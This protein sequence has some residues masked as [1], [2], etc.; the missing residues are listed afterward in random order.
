MADFDLGQ[1]PEIVI[2]ACENVL[3]ELDFKS[4]RG[5]HSKL[6]SGPETE[7]L[8][9]VFGRIARWLA[10]TGNAAVKVNAK[11][12]HLIDLLPHLLDDV[13]VAEIMTAKKVTSEKARQVNSGAKNRISEFALMWRSGFEHGVAALG[14]A[15]GGAPNFQVTFFVRNAN[16]Q[17]TFWFNVVEILN[18]QSA[19][20]I[21]TTARDRSVSLSRVIREMTE[22]PDYGKLMGI[23][24]AA[25][26][27]KKKAAIAALKGVAYMVMAVILCGAVYKALPEDTQEAIKKAAK[28]VWEK[29]SG[30]ISLPAGSTITVSGER[31]HVGQPPA[32]RIIPD[33]I[34]SG[35]TENTPKTHLPPL[36]IYAS[37]TLVPISLSDS[38]PGLEVSA[39][40]EPGH[41]SIS[42]YPSP[43]F[44][45]GSVKPVAFFFGDNT[46]AMG[47]VGSDS[48]V[49]STE[50]IFS[51]LGKPTLVTVVIY[52]IRGSDRV[53][54]EVIDRQVTIMP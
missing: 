47:S 48:W 42:A 27:R 2:S 12:R 35:V 53:P 17:A 44:R 49:A 38:G 43:R 26:K 28:K 54:L 19:R 15:E 52:E 40:F 9:A 20:P 4:H 50:H 45:N 25:A 14:A 51:D 7:L 1:L 37:H 5:P 16:A 23:I 3:A 34:H 21:I 30:A 36:V 33:E 24:V 32:P 31:P 41:V 6:A 39:P 29:I 8:L 46:V 18:D 22:E 10:N 11:H 13:A